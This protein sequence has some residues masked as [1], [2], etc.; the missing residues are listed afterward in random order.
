MFDE[1]VMRHAWGM[2]MNVGNMKSLDKGSR[3][4]AQSTLPLSSYLL[5]Q[6]GGEP[7]DT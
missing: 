1:I 4:I 7:G 5:R 2:L 3:G 6:F